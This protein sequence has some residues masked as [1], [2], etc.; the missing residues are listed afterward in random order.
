MNVQYDEDIFIQHL[1]HV[2]QRAENLYETAREASSP[3]PQILNDCLAEL[4]EALE[5]LHVA[6][7]ELR[8]Q[9]EELLAA[10]QSAQAERQRYQELFDFAPEAYLVTDTYGIIQEANLAATRLLNIATKY[11][12]GK[13]IANFVPE[14]S[15][16]TFRSILNQLPAMNRMQEWEVLLHQRGERVFEAALTVETVRNKQGQ[17]IALRW[18]IRDITTRKQAEEQLQKIQIQNLQLIE[19]D[20]LRSEFMAKMSHELRTPMNAI[21]GFSEL[22]L[23]RYRTQYDTQQVNMIERIFKNG[24]HLLALIEEI[25][26]FSTLKTNHFQLRLE[27]FNLTELAATTAEEMRSLAEQKNIDFEIHLAQPIVPV[28]NDPIRLRQ[29]LVN[30]LSNAIKFTDTGRVWLE[31][32][33]LPGE[34]VAIAVSDTGIGIAPADQVHIFKEFW[35]VHQTLARQH[36]GTGLGLSISAALVRLMQGQI[37]VRSQIGEGS[38]FEI[39]LPRRVVVP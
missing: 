8:L 27:G 29:V 16:Q 21:L 25:L 19:A 11:L 6:E 3:Q 30:L 28:V 9:N 20:R 24:N 12:V 4:R 37:S 31:V 15:R 13:P 2:Q 1:H 34:R 14:E 36:S 32:W 26:D 5:E 17:A 18:L 38:T 23:R 7:E 33:E 39:E 22:L 35:Q 10:H